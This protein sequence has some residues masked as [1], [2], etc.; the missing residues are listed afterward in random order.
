M[1][2]CGREA[3]RKKTNGEEEEEERRL[4][5]T[6]IRMASSSVQASWP[7]ELALLHELPS[8]STDI[9][10]PHIQH[11]CIHLELFPSPSHALS[12]NKRIPVYGACEAM[13]DAHMSSI[14]SYTSTVQC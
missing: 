3:F 7:L 2:E 8:A 9:Y 5:G 10:G 14:D 12:L 13:R 6:I 4:M 11:T 1:A